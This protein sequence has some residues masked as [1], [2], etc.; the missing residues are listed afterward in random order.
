MGLV[1]FCPNLLRTRF[2]N[3]DSLWWRDLIA[4]GSNVAVGTDWFHDGIACKI[5]AVQDMFSSSS[6]NNSWHIHCRPEIMQIEARMQLEE[7]YC[8]LLDVR[9]E[10]CRE[11]RFVWLHNSDGIYSVNGYACPI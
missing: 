6:S 3:T 8:I 9:L 4:L 2:R 11:D 10:Q 5:G 1:K 7:L